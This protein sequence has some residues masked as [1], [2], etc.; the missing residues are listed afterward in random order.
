MTS[1]N[2]DSVRLATRDASWFNYPDV[3]RTKTYHVVLDDGAP[4]CNR[5]RAV[6]DETTALPVKD[7][8]IHLRC[9]RA[10]CLRRWEPAQIDGSGAG[11]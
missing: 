7:V 4:A 10:A 3:R 6:L 11:L 5:T 2:P 8:A 9:H 1:P